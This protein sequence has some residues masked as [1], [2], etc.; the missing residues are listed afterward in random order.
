MSA[1][2]E[3]DRLELVKSIK[4]LLAF[5]GRSLAGWTRWVNNPDT[6]ARFSQEELEDMEKYFSNFAESFIEY[7]L[8]TT[9]LG[10]EKGL[11]RK[12]IADRKQF[13]FVI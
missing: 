9:K 7:D 5:T 11:K 6:M 1:V 10:M 4:T 8:N 2:E 13:R 3:K 12:S